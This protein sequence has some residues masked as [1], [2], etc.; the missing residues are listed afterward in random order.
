MMFHAPMPVCRPIRKPRMQAAL[1]RPLR[2]PSSGGLLVLLSGC[3]GSIQ[4]ALDPAGPAAAE[5][6]WLWWLML[7]LA[8]AVLLAVVV[9]LGVAV[10]KRRQ[11]DDEAGPPLGDWWFVVLSGLVVPSIILVALLFFTLR[12]TV[13]LRVP[14]A[15]LTIQVVG[16]KWWWEIHYPEGG[17][18]TANEIHIPAGQPV[19]LELSSADVIHSFWVPRLH[20]K[21]DLMPEHVNTF[22]IMA[23]EPGVFRGQCAE[24]C[25]TQHALM[26]LM[27]VAHA[28]GDFEA[29]LAEAAR[30]VPAPQD[31]IQQRGFAVFM[32]ACAH[33]HAIAGTPADGRIGPDLTHMSSRLTI[34]AGTVPNTRGNLSGWI[35][36]P[37]PLKPGNLMPPSFLPPED[38]HALVDYLQSLP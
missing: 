19:R 6:A 11:D 8:S 1:R 21:M 32:D 9:L 24:F 12:T 33:C 10:L 5:I 26:A 23:D 4:S 3:G 15:P 34:G 31:S 22:W 37:Q 2:W 28:P 38:L 20:G 25:G 13:S 17:V 36:D 14:D 30:P 29:W 7:G 18:T 16:H 35:A 27:V